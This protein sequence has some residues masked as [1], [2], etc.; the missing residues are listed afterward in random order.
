[1]KLDKEIVLMLS[2]LGNSKT[3]FKKLK[4]ITIRESEKS[5]TSIN[6]VNSLEEHQKEDLQQLVAI[7]HLLVTQRSS[8]S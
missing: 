4:T 1:M 2:L 6:M 7:N 8:M 5:R 3:S